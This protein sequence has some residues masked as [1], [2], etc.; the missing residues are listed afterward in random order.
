MLRD[1]S[2]AVGWPELGELSDHRNRDGLTAAYR[3]A[4]PS[5]RGARLV[6][7]V[8]QLHGFAFEMQP[9]DLVAVPLASRTP[10]A[11][12][13]IVGEYRLRPDASA[14]RP[15][16]RAVRWLMLSVPRTEWDEELAL[17]LDSPL[18][19]HRVRRKLA[20]ERVRE[21]VW[22][23]S[24][25][26]HGDDRELTRPFEDQARRLILHRIER[27]F[28]GDRITEL[29]EALFVIRGKIVAERRPANGEGVLAV[30]PGSGVE[31]P[32]LCVRVEASTASLGSEAVE[33]F[34][35]AVASMSAERGV[36]V[37]LRGFGT[38]A[39]AAAA[40]H[41]SRVTLWDGHDLLDAVLSNY[42]NLPERFHLAVPLKRVWVLARGEP[43]TATQE[44]HP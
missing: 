13:E 37:C 16:A 30:L 40:L 23:A 29:V 32:P 6:R 26:S 27:E 14:S 38:A 36:L 11:I 17:E 7:D 20:E 1:S 19:V 5:V 34:A 18:T 41:A 35:R 25:S 24:V 4:Y 33:R 44:I 9:G 42:E 39:R 15:H 21:L 3:G 31:A 2:I 12:G 22:S 10:V 28:P 8:T 43:A